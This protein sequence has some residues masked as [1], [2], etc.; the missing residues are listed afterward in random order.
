MVLG[1]FLGL[2]LGDGPEGGSG[3]L[4]CTQKVSV[5]SKSVMVYMLKG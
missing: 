2:V 4:S 5:V 3:E 1:L